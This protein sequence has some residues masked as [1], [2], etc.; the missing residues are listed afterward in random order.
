[1]GITRGRL[2]IDEHFTAVPNEWARDARLSRRARGLLVEVMSHSIG[3]HITIRSLAAAGKEGKDSIQTALSELVEHGYVR[4][5]QG[6]AAAGKFGEIEYELCDPPAVSGFSGSGSAV[7]GSAGSGES[8][9]KKNIKSEDHPE[10]HHQED[11]LSAFADEIDDFPSKLDQIWALWPVSRRSTRKAVQQSL[12][13]AMKVA[14]WKTIFDAAAAHA[15]VWST[16]PASEHRF[17]PLLSTW[18]NK[19]RWTDVIPQSRAVRLTA[20]DMG[21]AADAL[22][23]EQTP[24]RALS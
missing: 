1:M 18:L 4:R 15:L 2:A 3:W 14:D 20:L 7:S 10:E 17:I 24:L 8:A 22:L 11:L 21:R 19:E 12:K 5:S 23:T 16:W 13:T 9:T 6:R